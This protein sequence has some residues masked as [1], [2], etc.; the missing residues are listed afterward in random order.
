MSLLR[1]ML[2]FPLHVAIARLDTL[3]TEATGGYN[4]VTKQPVLKLINPGTSAQKRVDGR[5][6]FDPLILKAQIERGTWRQMHVGPN[7]NVPDSR[8]TIVLHMVD[9]EQRGLVGADGEPALKVND[10]ILGV[11]ANCSKAEAHL[12][13]LST[14][15]D[16]PG[17]YCTEAGRCGDGLGGDSNLFK[18]TFED[19]QNGVAR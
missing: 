19:R 5:V 12:K 1:G 11:Y 15:L 8:L 7:G 6:Y 10:K 3:T 4:F 2:L 18:M 9:L 13:V 14:V 17:L 16:V